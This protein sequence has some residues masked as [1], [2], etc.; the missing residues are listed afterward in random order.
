[1]LGVLLM[2]LKN[3]QAGPQQALELNVVRGGNERAFKRAVHGLVVGDFVGDI[4]LVECR[5]AELGQFITLGCS[6][7]GECGRVVFSISRSAS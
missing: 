3:L 4:G 1:M 6:L 5:A 2:T 7:L